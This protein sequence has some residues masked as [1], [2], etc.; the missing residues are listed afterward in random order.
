MHVKVS[1]TVGMS[2]VS[3][4]YTHILPVKVSSILMQVNLTEF[5]KKLHV[6]ITGSFFEKD[7]CVANLDTGVSISFSTGKSDYF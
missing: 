4:E 5:M 2:R 7:C 3:V 6:S 1:V